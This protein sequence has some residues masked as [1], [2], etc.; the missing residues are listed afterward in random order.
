MAT[1][2]V[3]TAITDLPYQSSSSSCSLSSTLADLSKISP[4]MSMDDLLK[5]INP[6]FEPEPGSAAN[7]QSG[8]V[9]SIPRQG[10][11]TLPRELAARSVD[12]VW[13]EMVERSD[14]MLVGSG[15]VGREEQTALEDFLIKA[16]AV[17]EEDVRGVPAVAVGADGGSHWAD[18][19]AFDGV[20]DGGAGFAAPSVPAF[21][22]VIEGPVVGGVAA[23][24]SRR[25]KR[26]V[27]E[28]PIDRASLQKQ[29]RMIKNRESAARSRERKQAYTS[30]LEAMVAQLEK[31]N[32]QLRAAEVERNNERFRQLMEFLLPVME[33]GSARPRIMH[34]RVSSAQW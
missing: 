19:A 25:G 18:A 7:A 1:S 34:R 22:K 6:P 20:G 12:E 23:E 30:E 8:A 5:L 4:S 31:E 28:A 27:Q 29:R 11:L 16:G 21:E 24:S 13:K 33:K 17:R 9:G 32:A 15:V 10:S 26:R 14:Q 3:V 2:K